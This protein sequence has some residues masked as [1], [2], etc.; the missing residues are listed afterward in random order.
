MYTIPSSRLG[1]MLL[2]GLSAVG[3]A[4]SSLGGDGGGG[5]EATEPAVVFQDDF[6][7]TESGWD[8]W[9][10]E[11]CLGEYADGAYRIKV[12]ETE[13][14]CWVTLGRDL[15]DVT[16]EVKAT[17][18]GGPDVNEFGIQCRYQDGEN[19]Y[20]FVVSSDGYYAIGKAVDDEWTDIGADQM[21]PSDAIRQGDATNTILAECQGDQLTLTVNGEQVAS[22]TDSTFSSGDVGLIAGTFDQ[23]GTDILFDD[24]VVREA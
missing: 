18:A 17:K 8:E 3:L 7:D 16:V 9:M 10:D 20:F 5:G 14:D 24:F 19:F 6:S 2:A 13:Y 22:V 21:Q 12:D 15:G 1:F 11:S 23:G 4:C